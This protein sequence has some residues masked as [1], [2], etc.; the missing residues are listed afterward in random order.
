MA[1]PGII[2]ARG[3]MIRGAVMARPAVLP[4]NTIGAYGPV[5]GNNGYV[6]NDASIVPATTVIESGVTPRTTVVDDGY[7]PVQTT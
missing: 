1:G 3:M 7:I 2:A 4:I 6:V 5:I